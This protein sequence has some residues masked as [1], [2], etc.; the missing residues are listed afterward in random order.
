MSSNALKIIAAVTVLLAIGL[1]VIAFQMTRSYSVAEQTASESGSADPAEPTAEPAEALPQAVV[2]LESLAANTPISEEQVRV[3][4][5]AVQPEG[6]FTSVDEVINRVPLVDIDAGAPVTGRYFKA[7]NPLARIIPE[8]HKAVSL[9]V[10]D[11]IAVGDFLQPGDTVDVLVYLRGGGGVETV[12][13]RELLGDVRVLALESRI[14]DRPEGLSDEEE[15]RR[16]RQRTVV[17]AVPE[18][19][20][21]RLMLGSSIGEVRL[22]MHGQTSE[23]AALDALADSA[24]EETADTDR[25]AESDADAAPISDAE[26][27]KA[28]AAAKAAA[29]GD[30]TA[31]DADDNPVTAARLSEVEPSEKTAAPRVRRHRVYVYQGSNVETVLD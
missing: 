28:A 4:P 31:K 19:K 20:V 24:P 10:D 14:I 22:A 8:G 3:A 25:S 30:E 7:S 2:A 12:Q 9:E 17:M 11:V 16:R 26:L 23:T 6:H 13:A 1:A 21:T 18:D 5:V 29:D 27:A 15:D